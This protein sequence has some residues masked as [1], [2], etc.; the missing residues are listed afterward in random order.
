VVGK[1]EAS[2]LVASGLTGFAEFCDEGSDLGAGGVEGA[3]TVDG[4]SGVAEFFVQGKLSGDAA[5]GFEF[6]H[7]AGQEAFELLFGSAEG[8]DEAIKASGEAGFDQ[9]CG[10]HKDDFA[11]AGSSP[12]VELEEHGLLDAGMENGVEANEFGGI[13]EDDSGE[14]GTIDATGRVG[15]VRA[16]LAED[17]VVC[18]LAGFHEFVRE[19]I[20]VEDREVEFVKDGGDDALAAGDTTG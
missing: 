16:E 1:S 20:G 15:Q 8:D 7:A 13:G 6:A 5:A 12:C 17:F 10:F 11:H 9:K 4:V 14:F 3:G 19:G 18:G 2:E